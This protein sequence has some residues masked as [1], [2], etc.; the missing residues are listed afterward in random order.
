MAHNIRMTL[1]PPKNELDL[2]CL[3]ARNFFPI[4]VTTMQKG[5]ICNS[6]RVIVQTVTQTDTHTDTDTWLYQM[7]HSMHVFLITV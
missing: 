1:N 5:D 7:H 3:L 6:F 2:T 4:L